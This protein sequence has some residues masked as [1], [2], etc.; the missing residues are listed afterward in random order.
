MATLTAGGQHHMLIRHNTSRQG[1]GAEMCTPI[2]EPARTLT[3]AGHQSLVGWRTP[4]AVADCTFRMLEPHEI[5][6]AMAFHGGY[7]VLGNRRERVRQLGNAVTP[8]AAE[9]LIRAVAAA[10]GGAA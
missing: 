4:P 1:D 7:T 2:G 10:L 8:P 5:Q 3:T 9:Y 6:A